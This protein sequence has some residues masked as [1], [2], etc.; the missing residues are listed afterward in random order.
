MK[1]QIKLLA[2][3][4]MK[5]TPQQA[6]LLLTQIPKWGPRTIKKAIDLA[7]YAVKAHSE[8]GHC[9]DANGT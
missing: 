8:V 9:I 1:A 3:I 7:G 5:L 6:A 4:A 2:P